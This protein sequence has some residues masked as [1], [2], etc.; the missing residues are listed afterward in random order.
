VDLV[1]SLLGVLKA[2][3]AYLPID[4]T[5]PAERI[6]FM[7]A[8]SRAIVVLGTEDGQ[9][10]KWA[11]AATGMPAGNEEMVLDVQ[12]DLKG[13]ALNPESI[14]G[15]PRVASPGSSQ[16]VHSKGALENV[17]WGQHAF[18]RVHMDGHGKHGVGYAYLLKELEPTGW[19]RFWILFVT[20][21]VS[22]VVWGV[23]IAHG[24]PVYRN[25]WRSSRF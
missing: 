10:V 12:N 11:R 2:G 4:V 23:C 3:A 5:L 20:F 14:L 1:V 24:V 25:R 6:R 22:A 17:F 9:T 18:V 15:S 8:D 13:V 19:Q 16:I 21:L 7:I